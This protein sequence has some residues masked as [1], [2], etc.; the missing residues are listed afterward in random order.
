M[1]AKDFTSFALSCP[2]DQKYKYQ[3]LTEQ[4]HLINRS[5][6][7]IKERPK[8]SKEAIENE[9]FHEDHK[10]S[11]SFSA[12]IRARYIERGIKA[13]QKDDNRANPS[14]TL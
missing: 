5:S 14:E 8:K 13:G 2:P 3:T 6:V 9:S 11:G 7:T 12:M 1:K 10:R 4:D